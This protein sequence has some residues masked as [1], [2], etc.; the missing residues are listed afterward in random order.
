MVEWLPH[1]GAHFPAGVQL[2]IRMPALPAEHSQAQLLIYLSDGVA[3]YELAYLTEV[4][5][6]L[7]ALPEPVRLRLQ[8]AL[9]RAG[10][11]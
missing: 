9:V 11:R 2:A 5:A 4:S 8:E 10:A 1:I 7:D 3:G 6:R